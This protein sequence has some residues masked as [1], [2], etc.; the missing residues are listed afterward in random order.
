MSAAGVGVLGTGPVARLFAGRL[1]ELGRPVVLGS[2]DPAAHAGTGFRVVRLAEAVADNPVLINATPGASSV[3]ALTAVGP[4]AFAGKVLID[5]AN[6]VTPEFDLAYPNASLGAALQAA[7]PD[8]RVVKAMNTAPIE[9]VV[10][11][12]ELA[13]ADLF[14]SGDDAAAKE[15]VAELLVSFG[16]PRERLLDL[17]GIRTARGPEH[18][19][20]LAPAL[21]G[22][23]GTP[24]L[25]LRVVHREPA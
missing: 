3:A 21:A 19:F 6:A 2:R 12:G 10:R 15:S 23:V 20:L 4:A 22:A 18:F 13:A 9:D 8:A 7:L 17:G 11:P 16:W 5:V 1:T 24:H 14:L 25:T